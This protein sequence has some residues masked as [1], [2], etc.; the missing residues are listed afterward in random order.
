MMN[1]ETMMACIDQHAWLTME[2]RAEV[3]RLLTQIEA[4]ILS[5]SDVSVASALIRI[6]GAIAMAAIASAKETN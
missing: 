2:Q 5:A 3:Q 6:Y 1:K 4:V